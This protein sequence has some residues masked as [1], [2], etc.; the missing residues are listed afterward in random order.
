MAMATARRFV[1]HFHCSFPWCAARSRYENQT[2]LSS[3]W[4]A[5][6]PWPASDFHPRD[7]S[8]SV[9]G[10]V[11]DKP[12][13]KS[14]APFHCHSRLSPSPSASFGNRGPLSLEQTKKLREIGNDQTGTTSFS[15]FFNI[16]PVLYCEDITQLTWSS[17]RPWPLTSLT[18]AA[19]SNNTS[20]SS[21]AWS[22]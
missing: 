9:W 13:R 2:A 16:L 15:F 6:F 14:P 7:F 20:S 10:R 17:L 22:K 5:A 18:S 1:I 4:A 19:A 8:R 11:G 12:W 21:P 3:C